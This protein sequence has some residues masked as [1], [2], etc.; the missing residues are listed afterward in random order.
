MINSLVAWPNPCSIPFPLDEKVKE[1]M[2]KDMGMLSV[3]A[4]GKEIAYFLG[5]KAKSFIHKT[6]NN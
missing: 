4:N 6:K 2:G 3:K 5:I 1:G